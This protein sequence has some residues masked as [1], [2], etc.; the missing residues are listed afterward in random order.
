MA[1][2]SLSPASVKINYHT[3]FA[4]HAMVLPTLE[5]FPT[6][7]T[8][9]LGSYQAW[10]LTTIDAEV[11]INDLVDLL[12]ALVP[13]TTIFDAAT[14]Y[15]QA[16]ATSPNIPQ[17]SAALTQVGSSGAT[18]LQEANSATFNFK[19]LGNGNAKIV[20]LDFPLGTGGYNAIHPSG[21]GADVLALAAEYE[22][23]AKAWAGRD[24]TR[25]NVLRK[26]TFDLNDKLQKEYRMG[27]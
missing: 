12:A 10:D 9:T 7:I 1:P 5:W 15:T 13:S 21:F 20:L 24:D 18:G 4:P 8:G 23:T 25:V 22:S 2:N 14:V 26:V 27:A 16:T 3:T 17:A 6:S 11:M 19:T